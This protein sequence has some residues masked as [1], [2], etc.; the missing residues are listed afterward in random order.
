LEGGSYSSGF[1]EVLTIALNNA[2]VNKHA[3]YVQHLSHASTMTGI[4]ALFINKRRGRDNGYY[5]RE[6]EYTW[7]PA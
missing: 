4:C 1:C 5:R 3:I 2:L 7:H 6:E